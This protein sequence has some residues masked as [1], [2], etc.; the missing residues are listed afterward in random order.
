M[1]HLS[2]LFTSE[3]PTLSSLP[4]QAFGVSS[5]EDSSPRRK[6]PLHPHCITSIQSFNPDLRDLDCGHSLDDRALQT[7]IKTLCCWFSLSRDSP[8]Q[9]PPNIWLSCKNHPTRYGKYRWFWEPDCHKGFLCFN[10][11]PHSWMCMKSSPL[12]QPFAQQ[13]RSKMMV[14]H[15]DSC[16]LCPGGSSPGSFQIFALSQVDEISHQKLR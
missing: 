5:C 1:H 13:R 3:K 8:T 7:P 12:C 9:D 10:I 6:G 14:G 4:K 15:L 2:L 11:P 16:C